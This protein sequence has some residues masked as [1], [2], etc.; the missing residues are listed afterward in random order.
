MI[1]IISDLFLR[2]NVNMMQHRQTVANA[3]PTQGTTMTRIGARKLIPNYVQAGEATRA[4]RVPQH[5]Y[6]ETP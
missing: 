3:F 4:T 5:G 1:S 6:G 2:G